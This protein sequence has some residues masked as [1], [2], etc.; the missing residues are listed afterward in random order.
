MAGPFAA[1]ETTQRIPTEAP[2]AAEDGAV[3]C[4]RRPAQ[5][6]I[7]RS[8]EE[9]GAAMT[10][11]PSRPLHLSSLSIG[12]FRGIRALEIPR[13]G[14][15]TLLAGRNGAG[16]TAVLEAVRLY[17][18]RSSE[19]VLSALSN[20][21]EEV[22]SATDD[23]GDKTSAPDFAALFHGRDVSPNSCIEIGPM[24][25]SSEDSLKIEK[26]IPGKELKGRLEGPFPNSALDAPVSI[27]QVSFASYKRTV[28]WFFPRDA[29]VGGRE[30]FGIYRQ[31]A[32]DR[33]TP[34]MEL[35]CQALGPGLLSAGETARL[36]DEI[37]LT[38][39]EDRVVRALNLVLDDKADRVA[40]IGEDH[41]H[42]GRRGRRV[43]VRLRVRDKPVPLRSL[44]DGAARMFGVALALAGSRGG[45]LVIDEVENGIHHS[46]HG[47]FWR[48]VLR[49]AEENDVRVFAATHS[50]DCVRGFA[51]AA[52]DSPES[53]VALAR[54]ERRDEHTR[55]V[56]YSKQEIETAADQGIEVR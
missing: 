25:G 28:P 48:M 47:D 52:A 26:V 17:A 53:E 24:G 3:T 4:L 9:G 45:F 42:F 31:L 38:D 14:R 40:M 32:D 16:K 43:V 19:Q 50:F 11:T 22:V 41:G 23:Y 34:P 29:R 44:G 2:F 7:R 6:R 21:H 20:G 56:L 8:A 15:V 5:D 13:L 27:I 49:T 55:A 10:G 46:A 54:L 18:S 39:N 51:R 30:D 12:G 35:N 1:A 37:A 33:D 36:W